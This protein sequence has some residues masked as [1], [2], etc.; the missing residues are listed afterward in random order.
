MVSAE[1]KSHDRFEKV[2]LLLDSVQ[3]L[4]DIDEQM[5]PFAG[6]VIMKKFVH[7]KPNPVGL[8]NFV[9]TTPTGI[10]WDIYLYEGKGT[11]VKSSLAASE[12]LDVGGKMVLKLTD[13]L[14][15]SVFVFTARYFT[16]I[17]LIDF[18][19]V[20]IMSYGMTEKLFS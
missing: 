1:E 3:I 17:P 15:L 6:Q 12:M 5:I 4:R 14:L 11:S 16:S 7:G 9:M 8:K 19:E 20:M 10:P 18:I 2:R 13:T